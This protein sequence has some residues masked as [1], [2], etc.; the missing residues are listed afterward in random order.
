MHQIS[1]EMTASCNAIKSMIQVDVMLDID[2]VS[3]YACDC[4]HVALLFVVDHV[5]PL[6]S[7]CFWCQWGHVWVGNVIS[8]NA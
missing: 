1:C 8:V 7:Y 4:V 2:F 6:Q 3:E 5:F